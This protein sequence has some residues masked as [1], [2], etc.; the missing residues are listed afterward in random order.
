MSLS[1]PGP[2]F[3]AAL[4]A[5]ILSTLTLCSASDP[6]LDRKLAA[7]QASI[8]AKL[9]DEAIAS[10][11]TLVAESGGDARTHAHLGVALLGKGRQE[12]QAVVPE[13]L[14]RA[15][16]ANDPAA[17]FDP[18]LF[19]TEVGYDAALK[20]EAEEELKKALAEDA[21]LLEASVALATVYAESDRVAEEKEVIATAAKQHAGNA[22]AGSRLVTFGERHFKAGRYP[23]ALAIFSLL[24]P[25]FPDVPAVVLDYS[26][27]LFG[28][29]RY[30]EGIALLEAGAV[31]HPTDVNMLTTLGQM[32]LYRFEWRKA[33]DTFAKLVPL[34]PNDI[35]VQVHQGAALMPIDA[36]K[37]KEVL[38]AVVAKNPGTGGRPAAIAK[39]LVIAMTNAAVTTDDTLRLAAD[40]MQLS[41][42]QIG[43]AVC[44]YVLAREPQNIGARLVLGMI[45]DAMRYYDMSLARLEE[46]RGLIDRRA[47]SEPGDFTLELLQAHLGRVYSHMGKD[48]E[49]IAAFAATDDPG[50]FN[51]IIAVSYERL[52]EYA[53]A[54]DHF[55][56]VVLKGEPAPQVEEAKKHLALDYYQTLRQSR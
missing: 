19:K 46:V 37:S 12:Q 1:H 51:L 23:E 34:D 13:Q 25:A 9:W 47:T 14:E 24:S 7:V 6:E 29:G 53:K 48:R 45:Y 16:Q 36:A 39:N 50:R 49:A 26:A 35:L 15:K 27:S 10:A 54:Y 5:A 20:T 40:L 52:G 42:A 44:G 18:S 22:E 32:Y 55:T 11:R 8:D 21:S 31:A 43:V 41:Y 4:G 30:D 28:M 56:R 33:A 38:D 2:W 3:R 17:F